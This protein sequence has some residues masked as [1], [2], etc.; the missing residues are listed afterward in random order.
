MKT[1]TEQPFWDKLENSIIPI[2]KE[3][4]G[5]KNKIYDILTNYIPNDII[6]YMIIPFDSE[7]NV[8][9]IG[10][11]IERDVY[12]YYQ[13]YN[14]QPYKMFFLN[15]V[16]KEEIEKHPEQYYPVKYRPHA[17]QK[18]IFDS[19]MMVLYLKDFSKEKWFLVNE[20]IGREEW[21]EHQTKVKEGWDLFYHQLANGQ[22]DCREYSRWFTWR[23]YLNGEFEKDI[24]LIYLY[25]YA[26]PC[27]WFKIPSD[28]IYLVRL[29]LMYNDTVLYKSNIYSV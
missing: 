22:F 4:K 23:L 12:W 5:R 20:D 18:Q 24:P 15:D 7:W 1:E 27:M 16:S 9:D 11:H 21:K 19:K 3:I 10:F 6:K 26:S 28:Q 2:R 25:R 29:E 8:Y 17:L 14:Y 13:P